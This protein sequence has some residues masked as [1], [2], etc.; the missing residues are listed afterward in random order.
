MDKR[1][2]D[3][4]TNNN[5]IYLSSEYYYYLPIVIQ[6]TRKKYSEFFAVKNYKTT[7]IIKEKSTGI[8]VHYSD[9]DIVEIIKM[10][11]EDN[12][13]LY[14]YLFNQAKDLLNKTSIKKM[15]F[16]LD[17]KLFMIDGIEL[18]T[19][20]NDIKCRNSA[21]IELYANEFVALFNLIYEKEK[22]DSNPSKADNFIKMAF[23]I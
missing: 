19:Q 17:D 3:F 13:D 4:L 18:S 15:S 1:K 2:S 14:S 10:I 16:K 8:K 21:D 7:I 9:N 11:N 5:D 6:D 23:A 22:T 20:F 12:I